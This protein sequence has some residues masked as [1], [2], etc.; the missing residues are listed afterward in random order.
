MVKYSVD[1]GVPQGSVIGPN[2]ILFTLY[3]SPLGDIIRHHQRGYHMYADDTQLYISI[4]PLCSAP[5]AE[6]LPHIQHC[7]EDI[8][9]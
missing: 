1:C 8:N 5:E 7:F 9:C 6:V 4:S 3:I 2:A